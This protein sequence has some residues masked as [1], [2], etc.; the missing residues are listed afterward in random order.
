MPHLQEPQ[1]LSDVLQLLSSQR[2]A[3]LAEC[4]RILLNEAMLQERSVTLRA[5][6][7]ERTEQRLG[8]TNSFK[9][10][11]LATRVGE[12]KLRVPRVRDVAPFYPSAL[13]TW[14]AQRAGAQPR[15]GRTDRREID[16]RRLPR[17]GKRSESNV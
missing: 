16:S 7:Y 17:R 12:V 8:R 1:L 11:T 14:R 5:Q 6:P 10:Y 13:V 9:P 3:S 4:F 2:S 15:H